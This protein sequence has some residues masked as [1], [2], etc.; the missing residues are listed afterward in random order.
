MTEPRFYTSV[1]DPDNTAP[2]SSDALDGLREREARED[3]G[4][5]RDGAGQGDRRQ[6]DR[7]Q[8]ELAEPRERRAEGLSARPPSPVEPSALSAASEPD[9]G[10]PGGQ[11][12]RP[13]VDSRE[14][15]FAARYVD[16]A[17][18]PGGEHADRGANGR[19]GYPAP[20]YTGSVEPGRLSSPGEVPVAR[21]HGA[22]RHPPAPASRHAGAGASA[23]VTASGERERPSG[24]APTG[25]GG[26]NSAAGTG[27]QGWSGYGVSSY[28]GSY[29]SGETPSSAAT[30][31]SSGYG[32]APTSVVGGP[33]AGAGGVGLGGA[34]LGGSG[35]T[36]FTGGATFGP[37]T[38]ARPAARPGRAAAPPRPAR[39]ARLLV[40]H[41]DPWST[42]KFSL[43]LA[44]ALFFVWLVAVGV[45]YGVLDG[46]GVFDKING[47]YD[48][49]AGNSGQRIIT[50]GLV[51]GTATLIGAVNIVL[52]TAL[53]TIGSFVYNICSDL[54]GG[55]EITLAERD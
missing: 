2:I 13:G 12:F 26:G 7:R 45:L 53:A 33:G 32:S 37:A 11:A 43:V 17:F 24:A 39:R 44:V 41:I 35:G 6:S 52:M 9:A 54:V 3:R 40:R 50:P 15:P 4:V 14:A 46:M 31:Y 22:D 30:P 23:G 28:A 25:Y 1:T 42:L 34:G 29:S 27:G 55:I 18:Q 20:S 16:P 8:G 10:R 5:H 47:L 51:L 36:P 48:E 21:G 49:L 38:A 19:P